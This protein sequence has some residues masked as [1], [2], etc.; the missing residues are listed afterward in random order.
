M[1]KTCS[2]HKRQ[3]VFAQFSEIQ[4]EYKRR[5]FL[6]EMT[7]FKSIA[8]FVVRTSCYFGLSGDKNQL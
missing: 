8:D 7:L 5:K 3:L 6:V 2:R 1:L 4:K